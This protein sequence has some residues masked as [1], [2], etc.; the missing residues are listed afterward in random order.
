VINANTNQATVP[1]FVAGTQWP[2][3]VVP[4]VTSPSDNLVAQSAITVSAANFSATLAAQS[5]TTF[6]GSP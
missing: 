5:V 2:A 3:S 4:W 6:V 1:L